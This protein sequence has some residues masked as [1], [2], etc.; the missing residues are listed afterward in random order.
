[1]TYISS[2]IYNNSWVVLAKA[3]LMLLCRGVG[4]IQDGG[5]SYRLWGGLMQWSPH[6]VWCVYVTSDYKY[7]GSRVS[8]LCPMR[9]LLRAFP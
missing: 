3:V 9:I 2:S 7:S 1:M 6:L 8:H 5:S 4:I